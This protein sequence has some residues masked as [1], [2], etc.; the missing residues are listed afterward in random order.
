MNVVQCI[1]CGSNRYGNPN[2]LDFH[3]VHD[4][5]RENLERRNR[6]L[7]D[8]IT[9][10]QASLSAARQELLNLGVKISAFLIKHLLRINTAEYLRYQEARENIRANISQLENKID[11][12]IGYQE[13]VKANLTRIYDYYPFQYPPDWQERSYAIKLKRGRKCSSC[14]KQIKGDVHLHHKKPVSQEVIIQRAIY[15]CSARGATQKT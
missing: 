2:L 3:S 1:I 15:R 8:E 10:A 6:S 11:L 14:R 7:P 5:C 9:Q 4:E 12:L 13:T